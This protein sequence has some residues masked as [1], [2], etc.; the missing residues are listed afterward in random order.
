MLTWVSILDE[1]GN[2]VP[3]GISSSEVPTWA[4]VG[5][6]GRYI[7]QLA[8]Q[9]SPRI[10][11]AI[12]ACRSVCQKEDIMVCA[13]SSLFFVDSDLARFEVNID[14]YHVTSEKPFFFLFLVFWQSEQV[15]GDVFF[16]EIGPHF[17]FLTIFFLLLE[18]SESGTGLQVF[19]CSLA[20][21][22][23][24]RTH[25]FL[26]RAP[27]LSNIVNSSSEPMNFS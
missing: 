24:L 16:E 25:S 22:L 8:C 19:L 10:S 20:L 15:R 1:A 17:L 9:S 6:I 13:L 14:H 11:I 18:I 5:K 4:S 23:L 7:Y 2:G 21:R 27:L 12:V 26:F 3:H